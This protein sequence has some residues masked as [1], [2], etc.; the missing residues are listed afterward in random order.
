MKLIAVNQ[1][2]LRAITEHLD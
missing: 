1:Q 2:K